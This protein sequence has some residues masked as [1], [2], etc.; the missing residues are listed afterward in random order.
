MVTCV[1]FSS[2]A[3]GPGEYNNR[4]VDYNRLTLNFYFR[5]MYMRLVGW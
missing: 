5:S 3:G 1:V 4:I 2:D